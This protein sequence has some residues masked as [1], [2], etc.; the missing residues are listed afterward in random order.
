MKFLGNVSGLSPALIKTFPGVVRLRNSVAHGLHDPTAE[1][2]KQALS[3]L[4]EVL[5]VL[6]KIEYESTL[7]LAAEAHKKGRRGVALLGVGEGPVPV[8]GDS[9]DTKPVLSPAEEASL[10]SDASHD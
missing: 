2:V 4:D 1:E 10:E 9:G 5:A 3:V 7:R 6:N 8:P